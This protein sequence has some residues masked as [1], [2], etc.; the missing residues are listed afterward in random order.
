MSETP[1]KYKR[2]KTALAQN[3]L[4]YGKMPPQSVELE[5][6]VLG[7]CMLDKNALDEV[8]FLLPKHFY[9]ECHERIFEA[10]LRLK[11]RGERPDV[12]TVANEL[13]KSGELDLIGGAWYIS[14]LTGRVASTANIEVHARIIFQN[15]QARE[16]IKISS[17]IIH[18]AY[19]DTTDVF[20]LTDRAETEIRNLQEGI[21]EKPNDQSI[22]EISDQCAQGL[23][24]RIKNAREG[25][26]TGIDTGISRLNK[27]TNGWQNSDLIIV[28]GRPGMGKTSLA[29]FWAKIAS[30]EQDTEAFV[31]SLEMP[32]QRLVDKIIIAESGV[33]ADNYN[34]GYTTTAETES[35]NIFMQKIKGYNLSIDDKSAATIRYMRTQ[36]KIKKKKLKPGQKLIAFIDYLQL[37][38]GK[39]GEKINR[40]QEIANISKGCKNIARD[41]NIPV[42]LLS[43]LNRDV[44]KRGGSKRPMLSD[45]RESGAIEQDADMVI[46][47]YRPEYYGIHE[48][49]V[50][51]P[52]F[53]LVEVIIAKHRYGTLSTVK[54]KTNASKTNFYD[55]EFE[56]N[57]EGPF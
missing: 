51:T 48:D 37:A 57:Q 39:N 56:E 47:L 35:A 46:F 4:E 22:R 11:D 20:D 33:N 6:T 36:L 30:M 41:L 31:F 16:L 21:D 38:D 13:K 15:W 9:K 7:A 53:N 50:G 5:E 1:E 14:Q 17:E 10:V 54:V 42:V 23:V 12:L 27:I 29:L 8:E 44:E 25:K 28:A 2:K 18:D 19:E 3:F 43:Q 40:E 55:W 45:L 32:A 26:M 34:S 52:T 49:E 24:D